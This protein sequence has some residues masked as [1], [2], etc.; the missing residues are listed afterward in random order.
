MKMRLE[1]SVILFASLCIFATGTIIAL[2]SILPLYNQLKKYEEQNLHSAVETKA[3]AVEQYLSKLEQTALQVT[4]RTRIR[5]LL[6]LYNQ[7]EMPL[8][9]LRAFTGPKLKDALRLSQEATGI[10]RFAQGGEEVVISGQ[11]IPKRFWNLPNG[12]GTQVVKQGPIDLSGKPYLLIKAPIMNRQEVQVGTDLVLFSLDSLQ[13][14]ISDQAGLGKSGEVTISKRETDRSSLFFTS[15]ETLPGEKERSFISQ[16]IESSVQATTETAKPLIS[17]DKTR[18]ASV[19]T[20]SG[21]DWVITVMMDR[22]ELYAGPDHQVKLIVVAIIVLILFGS[23][24]MVLV[25]R[26]LAGKIIIHTGRLEQEVTEKTIALAE[27]EDASRKVDNIIASI[28]EGLI[29]CDALS[30]VVLINHVAAEIFDLEED[31]AKGRPL[32]ATFGDSEF[33]NVLDDFLVHPDQGIRQLDL[34]RVVAGHEHPQH[35]RVRISIIRDRQGTRVGA[36]AIFSDLTR[37]HE[38]ARIK[39]EFLSRAAHELNTPLA[40]IIGYS[41]LLLSK[42]GLEHLE[43]TQA[44]EFLTEIYEKGEQ[45]NILVDDLLDISRIE[46]GMTVKLKK[47]LFRIEDVIEKVCHQFSILAPEHQIDLK[48]AQ[49][50]PGAFRFDQTRICEVL[51]NLL[52]NAVKYSPPKSTITV[53][54]EWSNNSYQIDVEDQGRGI[55]AEHREKIFEKFYRIDD[56]DS[57]ASGLGLGLN[58]VKHIVEAHDGRIW[59]E[60]KTGKGA[61][62]VFTLPTDQ[63]SA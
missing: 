44:R 5:D 37:E 11:A 55:S 18:I 50:G 31:D 6:E 17:P 28:A 56:S 57:S 46:A 36:V 39:N 49:P 16:A 23:A 61:R 40:V 62:I 63:A 32:S 43:A 20:I 25:L 52:S 48:L 14:I 4:S 24:G 2:L 54:S 34:Q 9:E 41:E 12:P 38:L 7:G 1:T 21:T 58:I 13:K 8:D 10:V 22:D 35:Y 60:K 29:V 42:D 3:L 45:L 59:V 26:P 30:R 19:T 15:A 27:A 33:C 53:R 51:E 47:G